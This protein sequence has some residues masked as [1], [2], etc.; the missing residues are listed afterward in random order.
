MEVKG[1]LPTNWQFF[2]D[3]WT[4]YEVATGLD[5]KDGKIRI[6]SLRTVMGKECLGVF[7]CLDIS[8]EDRTDP[9]KC[10][11][12]LEDYFEPK[13]NEIYE[14]YLFYTC[15]QGPNE[16][17]DTWVTRLRQ[18]IKSC[19]F[20]AADRDSLLRDR[21][22]LGTKDKAARLRMFREKKLTLT[23]A[24]DM[25][26]AS[27]VTSSQIRVIDKSN[28]DE[29]V[30]FAKRRGGSNQKKSN[31][32]KSCKFCLQCHVWGREHCPAYGKEC[33]DCGMPNHARGSM[34]C[35]S[36]K[37]QSRKGP[38]SHY[39]AKNANFVDHD[40]SVFSEDSCY[41]VIHTV[42]HVKINK[43]PR[44]EMNFSEEKTK[45]EKMKV[46][47]IDTGT[48]CNVM[49][50]DDLNSLVPNAKLRPSESRLHLYDGS[51]MKPLGVYSMYARYQGKVQRL[52]FEI[53]STAVARKPLLSSNT[54]QRLG[55]ISINVP[56]SPPMP[57]TDKMKDKDSLIQY[58]N[59]AMLRKPADLEQDGKHS[60]GSHFTSKQKEV[61]GIMDKYKDVFEGLGCLPGELHLEIDD[62]VPPVQHVPRKVPIAI[63]SQVKE[64]IDSMVK[65]GVLAKVD[66]PTDWISSMV[67]V[68]RPD[69]LRICIDPKDLNKALKRNKHIMPTIEDVLPELSRA[70]VFSVL[71]AK[72]GFHQI[73]LDRESSDLTTFWT[74]FGRYRWLRLPFG[75]SPAPEEYQM[76]QKQA[77]EGIQGIFGIADDILCVGYGD[78]I[79]EATTDHDKHLESL[80]QRCRDVNLKLNRKKAKLRLT[81]VKYVG[82]ILSANGVKA[83]PD[84]IKVIQD[85]PRPTC[86]KEV[87]RFTGFIQYLAKFLPKLS[88]MCEPLRRLTQKGAGWCWESQQENA[89]Q[90]CKRLATTSPV[91][92]YYDDTKPLTLQVDAS[93]KSVGASL[94]QEGQ[95]VY[96]AARALTSTEQR[97]ACIERECLAICFG[98]D[99]FD[100]YLAGKPDVTVVE[101]DH[102]PLETIFKKSVLSAP[103]RLQRMLMKLQRYNVDVQYR[104]GDT[105]YISDM[106]SRIKLPQ[107]S[108]EP[109]EEYE[110]FYANIEHITFAE[111]AP[112][113]TSATL[114]DIQRETSLDTQLQTLKRTVLSGWPESRSEANPA[115]H[116]F[117]SYRDEISIYDGVL[118][119]GQR[120]IVPAAM[121]EAMLLKIHA[122]HMGVEACINKTKDS[123]Y[124]PG[125]Y[126]DIQ[127]HVGACNLC[128]ECAPAQAHQPL[129]TPEI[130]T[131]PWQ[132]IA[133][134]LFH[135]SGR[136]YLITVDYFSD[137]FEIDRLYSTTS[138]SV[139]SSLEPHLARNGTV[140]IL[141]SDNGPNLV[142]N[143]FAEFCS[144]WEI[145]H[146]TMSPY[147]SMSNGKIEA[148]VKIAKM[149]IKKCR[150]SNYNIHLALLDYR[151][152]PCKHIGLSPAQRMFSRR[153]KT[154]LPISDQLL[155][156][157]V[158]TDVPERIKRKRQ[159]AKKYFDRNTKQL[160]E[161]VTGQ[162]VYLRDRLQQKW[163]PGVIQKALT[164]RS[165]IVN[166]GESN[167]A[168]RRNRID[169]KPR[170]TT[171]A[172]DSTIN[173]A[174]VV[175]G[176]QTPERAPEQQLRRSGRNKTKYTP[177]EHIP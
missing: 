139:I 177:Y 102:K 2:K 175:T 1:D 65:S 13:R 156:P 7:K 143:E 84:K 60:Q 33:S 169:V 97:Y 44:V 19:N 141:M 69:K 118:F 63:K 113:F 29:T 120:V 103:K 142:S 133:I 46:C 85:M 114:R 77:L 101:S 124:W 6:A 68:K 74:P 168:Y 80:L 95:P 14:R 148:T 105:M 78:T 155:K 67:V 129:Q 152:T 50:I 3:Q 20:G 89:F 151:N 147:H 26:R 109:K 173:E 4:D 167:T 158:H 87:Q 157:V 16:N 137:Y 111:S 31:E 93:E 5:T 76:R 61:A 37:K 39:K 30:N 38:K 138:H 108:Q 42:A 22:V 100:Q 27:E 40:D 36:D 81:E 170:A 72:D 45:A 43:Q 174:P 126:G 153:T 23:T 70:K 146:V 49:S 104:K 164:D 150:K 165:Y 121:R 107:T 176:N 35:K 135:E 18:M 160:P 130:P 91:L 15:D 59:E 140:D 144:R 163:T 96:F 83:D 171:P 149:L 11:Q 119:K 9:G 64:K 55:L 159:E 25:L 48:S 21:L 122:A 132:R 79:E 51:Y 88:D 145:E 154:L 90:E 58:A 34:L 66:E 110:V 75:I 56:H 127:Q 82:H 92:R 53:V 123:M 117:W 166:A 62:S 131:R 32:R 17:V 28:A 116:E 71:D 125:I 172:R 115:I 94:L 98:C 8:D 162:P 112:K 86:V 57:A 128:Q 99:K 12:A 10:L 54:C 52:R 161:L 134:D 106:L 73:K 41:S 24:I 136:D 47:V